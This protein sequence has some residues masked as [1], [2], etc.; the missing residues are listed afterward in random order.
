MKQ[1]SVKIRPPALLLL[2]VLAPTFG[3]VSCAE[4]SEANDSFYDSVFERSRQRRIETDMAN[5][6]AGRRLQYHRSAQ[7]LYEAKRT[8]RD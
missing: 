7:H 6:K 8:G 4:I 3:C 5:L 1:L 2:L